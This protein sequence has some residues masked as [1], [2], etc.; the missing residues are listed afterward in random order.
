MSCFCRVILATNCGHLTDFY[1]QYYCLALSASLRLGVFIC[2][3]QH[4]QQGEDGTKNEEVK[5][6]EEQLGLVTEVAT[7]KV[8]TEQCQVTIKVN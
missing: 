8:K 4:F 1:R 3:V 2:I 7:L 5:D 6:K